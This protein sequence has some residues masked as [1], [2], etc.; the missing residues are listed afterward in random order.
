[1]GSTLLATRVL[2]Q[3]LPVLLLLLLLLLELLLVCYCAAG[4]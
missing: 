1:V 2:V 4:S 3:L